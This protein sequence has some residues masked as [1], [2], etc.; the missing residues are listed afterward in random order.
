MGKTVKVYF[1]LDNRFCSGVLGPV[2]FIPRHIQTTHQRPRSAKT[3]DWPHQVLA[4]PSTMGRKVERQTEEEVRKRPSWFHLA[5]PPL[6]VSREPVSLGILGA[7]VKQ[8]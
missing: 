2:G 1:L 8:G 5:L 7:G 3:A 4:R 6:P